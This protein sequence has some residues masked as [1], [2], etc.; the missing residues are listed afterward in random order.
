M[1]LLPASTFLIIFSSPAV[2]QFYLEWTTNYAISPV[3]PDLQCATSSADCAGLHAAWLL[4]L[5][6]G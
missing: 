4:V 6:A 3:S 2:S 5:H 1:D